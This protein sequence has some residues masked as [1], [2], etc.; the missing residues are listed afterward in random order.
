MV[1]PSES[2]TTHLLGRRRDERWRFAVLAGAIA[3][4]TLLVDS[5][6]FVIDLSMAP[7]SYW[8]FGGCLLLA[9]LAGFRG[10]GLL[11]SVFAVWVLG[12]A[13]VASGSFAGFHGD[14]TAW[15]QYVVGPVVGGLGVGIP[16]GLVGYALGV[17]A[18]VRYRKRVEDR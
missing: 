7:F 12:A 17:G 6:V 11:T 3:I 4:A 16:V 15:E 10:G 18:R 5:F 8:F 9:A 2:M 14:P 13:A 1:S